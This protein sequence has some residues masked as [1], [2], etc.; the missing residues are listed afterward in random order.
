[1]VQE[2]HINKRQAPAWDFKKGNI[3]YLNTQNIKT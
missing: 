3:V 2:W 1:M